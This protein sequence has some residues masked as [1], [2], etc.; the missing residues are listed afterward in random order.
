VYNKR[1]LGKQYQ[2]ELKRLSKELLA[3][4]KLHRRHFCDHYYEMKATAGQSSTRRKENREIIPPIKDHNGKIIT[5][6]NE[7]ANIL[8]SYYAS[9][10]CCDRNV[11][12]IKL[13]NSSETFI[14][15]TKVIR[16]RSAKI[17]INKSV[18][19]DGVP[20]EILKLGGE[21]MTLYLARLLEISL[22]N[23]TISSDWNRAT[24]VPIYKGGD[25]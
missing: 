25:R 6:T 22:K 8:N 15:N 19:P 16:K 1:K 7:K 24:V 5:D 4:K 17:G 13:A 9:V 18:V 14:I 10:F 20:G 3:A 23:A 21:A 11:P 2:E 12:Q